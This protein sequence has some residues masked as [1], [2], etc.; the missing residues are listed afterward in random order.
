MN[1]GSKILLGVLFVIC[2]AA[3]LLIDGLNQD[4]GNNIDYSDKVAIGFY[5]FPFL[6]SFYFIGRSIYKEIKSNRD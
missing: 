1:T 3:G 6:V 4:Y 2:I 5:M